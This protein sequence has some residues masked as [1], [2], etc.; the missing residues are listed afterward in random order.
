[1]DGGRAQIIERGVLTA[2]DEAWDVAVRQAEVIGRLAA[3]PRVGLAAADAAASELGISQRQVYVL[4]GRWR[5]GEGVVSDLLPRRSSGGRGQGRLPTAV[6]AVLREVIDARYLNRQRRS[7]AAVYREVVRRC[8]AGGL[9]VPAR[10][11][12]ARRIE[13]LDG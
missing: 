5:A 3:E 9:S 12:L 2:P 1:M 10:K 11:T 6:E 4:L 8:R 13:A 7:V